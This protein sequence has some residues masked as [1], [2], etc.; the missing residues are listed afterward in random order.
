MRSVF[1]N[2]LFAA[3]YYNPSLIYVP[4]PDVAT[5]IF[6]GSG[7]VSMPQRNLEHGIL[8]IYYE[9]NLLGAVNLRRFAEKVSCAHGRIAMKYP[10]IARAQVPEADYI[11]V[12]MYNPVEQVVDV[13]NMEAL[14]AWCNW[15]L[16]VSAD[17][18]HA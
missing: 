14:A 5:N 13:R 3:G 2:E 17:E 11:H 9:G 10:T 16:P 7:I 15:N 4:K 18:L 12:G 6:H 8:N 1:N